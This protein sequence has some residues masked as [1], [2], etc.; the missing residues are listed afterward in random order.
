MADVLIIDDDEG[1]SYTLTRMVEETGNH[2]EAVLTLADGLKR[3]QSKTFDVVLLDVHL[4]DGNGLSIIPKLQE[5]PTPPEIIIIT[6]Y[7]EPCGA[8]LAIKSGVWDYIEKPASINKMKLPLIRALQYSQQ[9]QPMK[10]P[11]INREGIIGSS[12]Q[13]TLCI[14]RMWQ[15][16][17]SVANVLILGETGTGKEL[18]ARKIHENSPRAKTPF[19]TVDCTNLP[20]NLI[21]S[22]LFGH[23]KGAFTGADSEQIGLIKQADQGTLFLDEVG[24]LPLALQKRFLRVLQ[25]RTYLPVGKKTE[26][27]SDFRLIVA[28]N[29]HPDQMVRQGLFRNDLLYRIQTLTIELPPLKKRDQDIK[30][31]VNHLIQKFCKQYGIAPKGYSPEFLELLCQYH[32]PGNIR[33]LVNTIESALN[34]ATDSPVLYPNHL[35]DQVRIKIKSDVLRGSFKQQDGLQPEYKTVEDFP[36]LNSLVEHVKKNYLQNLMVITNG[37]I[38]LACRISGLSRS[39]LYD[40]IKKYNIIRNG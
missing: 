16:A 5:L 21:E 23:A 18:F 40:H 38:P 39:G 7:G 14:D 10:Q 4:P 33:E 8:E 29:R 9:K 24:E 28:T 17:N 13:V 26:E 3:A 12:P 35:P 34:A 1:M 19:V 22:I 15:A 37:D 20:E 31:L 25:E 6:A 36:Q 11:P 32:W 30:E 2:P 27:K